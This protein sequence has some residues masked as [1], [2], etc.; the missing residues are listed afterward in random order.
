[1][2]EL[3][4]QLKSLIGDVSRI[5]GESIRELYGR[6]T[7]KIIE[8]VRVRMKESRGKNHE[9][10]KTHL[11]GTYRRF[12][13][14]PLATLKD[15]AHI[16]AVYLEL[17]N[18]CEAAFRHYRIQQKPP[19]PI[20]RSPHA[21]ICVFTAHPTEAKDPRALNLFKLTDA[22]LIE[23][24]TSPQKT[25]EEK[26]LK[27][28]FKLLLKAHFSKNVA[29]KVEDEI[30][31]IT[32]IVLDAGLVAEQIRLHQ[33]GIVVHFRTW[34]GGDKDGHPFVSRVQMKKCLQ[35]SRLHLAAYA[36]KE[37][38]ES[39]KLLA[40]VSGA[41]PG[42]RKLILDH[43]SV[44]SKIESIHRLG[45]N[46]GN[47]IARLR[48]ACETLISSYKREWGEINHHLN[49]LRSLIWLY[50]ALILPLELRE[51]SAVVL[52]S[53]AEAKKIS[54]M[55]A[56][57][58]TIARGADPKWYVKGFILS[59]VNSARDLKGGVALVK[60]H[61]GK[62]KIPV[63]PLFETKNALINSKKI[64]GEFLE[65]DRSVYETCREEWDS[66]FEVMLGYSD[67]AKEN[68]TLASRYLIAQ[69]MNIL[70]SYLKEI[71]LKPIFFHGS[72]GSVERG[73]GSIRDQVAWMPQSSLD[74]FKSTVQGEMVFRNFGDEV[75][76]R[77][78]VEKIVAEF[79]GR[80]RFRREQFPQSFKKLAQLASD[81]YRE[82]V[83][84]DD[85]PAFVKASTPYQF[86]SDLKIGSR[87]SRRG[88]NSQ[89]KLRAIPWVLCWTQTRVLL[90]SWWGVGTAW[91][92]LVETERL[93]LI[94]YYSHSP[95]F[96]SYI[97]I[98]GFT[99]AKVELGVFYYYLKQGRNSAQAERDYEVLCKEFEL[100]KEFF[101]KLTGQGE[102]LW[103][104]PWLQESIHLRSPM[105][106]PLN[107]IQLRAIEKMNL[108][109]LRET[110][111]GIASGMMTTG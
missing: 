32:S 88:K 109:L 36:Q 31:H 37:A 72:G 28:L 68:G 55:L 61:F 83:T 52:G 80:K 50:P 5:Y 108:P 84:A 74:I 51:D 8:S 94:D 29:P 46:D 57:I 49:N 58:G 1:M 100:T 81:A 22:T 12:K 19:T 111:S 78:M 42:V 64:L 91:K 66:H 92:K 20:K 14:L 73:G 30:V 56:T 62:I 41:G 103:F 96:Q 95:F 67:S 27:H 90:P 54:D 6:R 43:E 104:R 60:K 23:W 24:L 26:R 107:F 15:V 98:L 106:H 53:G 86:L 7:F 39:Q 47:K 16:L 101:Y 4:D 34:V 99:L 110:V 38:A 9:Q 11:A 13:H 2:N 82:L 3:P 10:L 77:S 69:T 76:M 79:A 93:E 85:F 21:V 97:K 105:I 35:T 71:K 40:N 48:R 70:D 87:P 102:F 75:I 25:R 65:A 89:F 45:K 44:L 33:Q 18:R 63:I 17:I 59:M